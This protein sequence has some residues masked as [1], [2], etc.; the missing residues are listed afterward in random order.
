MT[1]TESEVIPQAAAADTSAG[2]QQGSPGADSSIPVTADMITAATNLLGSTPVFWGRYF[3]SVTTTGDVEYRHA[4]EN[5]PLHAAGIRLLPICRQTHHVAGN[6]ALGEADGDANAQDF[7]ETFGADVLTAQGGTF[8][9]FLDVEGA[10][11]L[12]ADYYT[13]WVS[14]LRQ[15]ALALT[16]GN[17]QILPGLYASQGDA[18]TWQA[19]AAAIN[20]GSICEGVW[21]ARYY[22]N[23][24]AL[25][26]WDDSIVT[27]PAPSPFPAPILA[28]QYAE[29]CLNGQIDTSQTNPGIDLN[30]D[31]LSYLVQP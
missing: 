16:G 24:C 20:A 9:L 4:I 15:A 1:T 14:G 12:S 8:I 13:G 28:W 31:L 26:N 17:V 21:I 27:P 25:G 2:A 18:A 29:N 5:A 3:T 6:A 30:N 7:I 19:L 22:T 10:P 11:S 23:Q